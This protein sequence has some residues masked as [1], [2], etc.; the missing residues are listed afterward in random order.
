MSEL[1]PAV[2]QELNGIL[3]SAIFDKR[4]YSWLLTNLH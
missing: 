4:I 3:Y 1:G 2:K